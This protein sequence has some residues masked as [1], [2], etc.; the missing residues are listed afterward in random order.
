MQLKRLTRS[1]QFDIGRRSVS[2]TPQAYSSERPTKT[3]QICQGTRL[4]RMA[5]AAG[6]SRILLAAV[7]ACAARAWRRNA[8][9][10][11]STAKRR[12]SRTWRSRWCSRIAPDSCGRARRTACSATT[13]ATSP[14]SP[15]PTA[16]RGRR[17][18]RCT[19]PWTGTLWVGT[20]AGLARRR[21]RTSSNR[22]RW[23]SAKGVAGRE[24]IASDRDGLPVRRHANG[25][26]GGHEIRRTGWTFRLI[27][28][29][30]G[31]PAEE[32][33]VSVYVD[34]TGIV[35]YGCGLT[36]TL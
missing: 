19:N 32:P 31:H 30:P 17:S 23:A 11:S 26:G 8:T 16:C 9:T 1:N 15:K 12:G 5:G 18:S 13:A 28:A 35:W 3:S 4:R 24:G 2:R 33:A 36:A 14:A 10:S 21:R 25:L 7:F 34:S 27:P 29:P 20:H 6:V 22:L